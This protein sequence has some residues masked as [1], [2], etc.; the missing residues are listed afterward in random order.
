MGVLM[1]I[2]V[3]MAGGG[4]VGV[5]S[6]TPL[7]REIVVMHYNIVHTSKMCTDSAQAAVLY[8]KNISKAK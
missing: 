1:G 7:D 8:V 4:P 2:P 3:G 5:Q 6:A